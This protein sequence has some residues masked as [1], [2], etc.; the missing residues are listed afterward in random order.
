MCSQLS[1]PAFGA[2]QGHQAVFDVS[3]GQLDALAGSDTLRAEV[4]TQ[5]GAAG[6]QAGR[7]SGCC[8]CWFAAL[9][10]KSG[11]HQ[12]SSLVT[13]PLPA[14]LVLSAGRA[15]QQR[16][17]PAARLGPPA[18]GPHPGGEP[19]AAPGHAA[20][21]AACA[22]AQ[23]DCA[24]EPGGEVGWVGGRRQAVE[25]PCWVGFKPSLQAALILDWL[26]LPPPA[27]HPPQA[28]RRAVRQVPGGLHAGALQAVLQLMAGALKH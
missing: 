21:G 1:C 8:T 19:R 17:E 20:A 9:K 26:E 7:C 5:V 16:Q 11:R 12:R 22:A 27:V 14:P 6:E 24:A 10:C 2:M 23:A 15:P 25:E 4:I 13:P 18:H 3:E 28:H